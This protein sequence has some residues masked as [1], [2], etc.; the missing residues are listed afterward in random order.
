VTAPPGGGLLLPSAALDAPH[1]P[2]YDCL[3]TNLALLAQS[4]F[5]APELALGARLALTPRPGPDGLPTVE[6]TPGAHLDAARELLGLTVVEHRA[7][8]ARPDVAALL[9]GHPAVYVVA[10]AYHLPWVPYRAHEH[11]D[12]SFLAE[13]G[14]DGGVTVLDAYHNDTAY[15]PARPGRWT[16]TAAHLADALPAGAT[17]TAFHRAPGTPAAPTAPVHR[18]P[19]PA[20]I[21]AYVLAYR[22]HPD[23]PTALRRLTLETWLLSRAR[24]LHA[25]YRA[26]AYGPDP[27]AEAHLAD[28][29]KLTEQTYLAHRRVERGRPEPPG[30]VDR[31]ATL[32][33]EDRE[34]FGADADADADADANCGTTADTGGIHA[35]ANRADPAESG[36][37]GAETGARTNAASSTGARAIADSGDALRETV[38]EEAAAVLRAA[39]ARLLAG[40]PLGAVPSFS[41]FRLVEIVERLEDRLGV[42]FD[43]DDL[44]P[45]NLHDLDSLCRIVRRAR[46]E[47]P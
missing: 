18:A 14:P 47:R 31:L 30:P 7:V 11:M 46:Q 1:A 29:A 21:E 15:G 2:L 6:P 3:Q 26:A 10:D 28:W 37:A 13:P 39:P 40:T 24:R 32:L 33:A 9:G 45:E 42:R 20:A 5:G 25:A 22:E 4:R 19:T 36:A 34:V 41:S 16:L 38:A 8:P 23:R 17:A 35:G 12:H 44:V 27:R 43:A